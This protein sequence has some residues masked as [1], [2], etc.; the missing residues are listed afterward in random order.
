MTL[1]YK[2]EPLGGPAK[3]ATAVFLPAGA[4]CLERF[5]ELSALKPLIQ[6]H[7]AS[8]AFKGGYLDALSLYPA[9]DCWLVLI[10]LGRLE[11]LTEA[12]LLEAAA[13]AGKT[14]SSLRVKEAVVCLPP[15][16]HGAVKTSELVAE[17]LILA[18]STRP[19]LKSAPPEPPALKSLTLQTLSASNFIDRSKSVISRAEAMA[20]AQLEAR[21]LTDLPA[22]ILTPE[23]L[24]AEAVSLG[25]AKMLKVTV[26]DEKKLQAEGAGGIL[27][28][29][30]GSLNPP[31]LVSIE[32]QGAAGLGSDPPV[33][34]VGKGVTFDSGG[35]CI[36]PSESMSLMKSDM[37]G[38]AA[39]LAVM[40]A[41]AAMRL[42]KRLSAIVPLAENM[43]SGAAFRPGDIIT[44]ANGKT[45]E[46]IN[47]DAEGR[48]LLADALSLAQKRGPAAV[49][50]I[51]TL[52]GACAVALGDKVAGLFCDDQK[53][54]KAIIDSGQAVGEAF[55]P[56]PLVE[57]YDDGL[58]SDLADCKH[59]A[60]R[61]GG[62]IHA[63]L[64]L[65]RFVDKSVPWAHLDI[66]GPGR[67]GKETP[68]CPEGA[69]G[70]GVRTILKM[71]ADG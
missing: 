15:L 68:S 65:R 53:L 60:S 17:G 50:D 48:L 12:R 59:W 10:G 64:F 7:L 70:F 30:Q 56:L 35:L 46:V 33:V 58:K 21:R 13:K 69:S 20:K 29:G 45:V 62:A 71:L 49:I 9:A 6:P 4:D 14:L 38:A 40:G 16:P 43:P 66:A 34:L 19:T 1:K 23:A 54:S 8:G 32:Y 24:A 27:A 41:A 57:A 3:P 36:K 2:C 47:T 26:W 42:P 25:K 63:A 28:V 37:A 22:N 11:E 44:C 67:N 52:T 31:R 51:A 39:V 61:T 18:L 5:D 55:W